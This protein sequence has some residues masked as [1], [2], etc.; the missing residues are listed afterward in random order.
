M[1]ILTDEL[2]SYLKSKQS[3]SDRC[4]QVKSMYGKHRKMTLFNRL[5]TLNTVCSLLDDPQLFFFCLMI[6]VHESLVGPEQFC[7]LFFR[8]IKIFQHLLHI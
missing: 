8:K 3:V 1:R 4:A 6:V 5:Y 2:C 7:L